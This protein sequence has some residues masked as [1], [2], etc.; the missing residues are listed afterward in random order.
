M[1][2]SGAK[3]N[4]SSEA[5]PDV[6]AELLD[7]EQLRHRPAADRQDR[8]LPVARDRAGDGLQAREVRRAALAPAGRHG[9]ARVGDRGRPLLRRQA[10]SGHRGASRRL[11]FIPQ[12]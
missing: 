8:G 7:R 3:R 6:P 2:E 12:D 1:V 5:D 4:G 11:T 9:A 10:R